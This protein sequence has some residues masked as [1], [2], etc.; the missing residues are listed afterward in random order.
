MVAEREGVDVYWDMTA[1]AGEKACQFTAKHPQNPAGML[2]N[3]ACLPC[4]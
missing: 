3:K 1:I 2:M 4:D